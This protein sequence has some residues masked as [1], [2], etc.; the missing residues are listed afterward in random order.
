MPTS[1]IPTTAAQA[2][3]VIRVLIFN[4]FSIYNTFFCIKN[5]RYVISQETL[6][7]LEIQEIPILG[8]LDNVRTTENINALTTTNENCAT[9]RFKPPWTAV[10]DRYDGK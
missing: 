8:P 6:S 4:F 2:I 10:L 3:P 7:E 1:A 5:M 9:S